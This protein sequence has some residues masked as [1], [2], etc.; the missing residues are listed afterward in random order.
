MVRSHGLRQMAHDQEIVGSNP[1]T[2]YWIDVSE[3]RHYIK[4]GNK[5]I[6]M[7]QTKQNY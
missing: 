2:I 7:G 5:G 4:N 3:A 6:Q 1:G